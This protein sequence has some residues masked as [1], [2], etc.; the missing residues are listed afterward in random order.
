MLHYQGFPYVLKVIYLKL[1]SRYYDNLLVSHFGIKKICELI[2]RKYYLPTLQQDIEAYIKGCNVYLASKT[3]FYKS[4]GDL[5][6][7]IISTH[8]WK[9]LLMDFVTSFLILANWKSDS[10]N[11]ILVIVNQLTKMVHFM[12]VKVTINT[13]G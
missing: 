12:P 9:D 10:Y 2:A 6:L 8:W 7:L 5:Q 3:V 13:Q 4:Y 1:I 11:S